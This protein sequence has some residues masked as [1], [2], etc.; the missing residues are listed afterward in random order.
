MDL[1]IDNLDTLSHR[2]GWNLSKTPSIAEFGIPTLQERMG[3][4][5]SMTNNLAGHSILDIQQVVNDIINS[6]IAVYASPENRNLPLIN[7]IKN[8]L[9]S[10][11]LLGYASPTQVEI[12]NDI[13]ASNTEEP[14]Q[15]TDDQTL[16]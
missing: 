10:D 15:S 12:L 2:R 11:G 14:L 1:P 5:S 6:T 4:L 8:A 13:L 9:E 3:T 16:H 7:Q